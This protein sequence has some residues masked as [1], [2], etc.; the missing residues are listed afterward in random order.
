MNARA[1]ALADARAEERRERAIDRCHERLPRPLG[2]A[3]G[4]GDDNFF[5]IRTT[6]FGVIAG[7]RA[8]CAVAANVGV[9]VIC[10]HRRGPRIYMRGFAGARSGWWS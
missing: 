9:V 8:A 4:D 3:L 7:H 10:A 6:R 5:G 2:R 1:S